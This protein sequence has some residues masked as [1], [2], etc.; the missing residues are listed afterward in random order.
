LEKNVFIIS[1]S[2]GCYVGPFSSEATAATWRKALPREKP[3][4]SVLSVRLEKN[5][6]PVP[7]TVYKIIKGMGKQRKISGME[8][9]QSK[10]GMGTVPIAERVSDIRHPSFLLT[11]VFDSVIFQFTLLMEHRC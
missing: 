3:A 5:S 6:K 9:R 10:R 4:R 7:N 8:L 11:F 2:T 1:G